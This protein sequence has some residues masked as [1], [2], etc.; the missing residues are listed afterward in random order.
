MGGEG[1]ADLI[2]TGCLASSH[3]I[4]RFRQAALVHQFHAGLGQDALQKG[5]RLTGEESLTEGDHDRT[6]SRRRGF[7]RRRDGWP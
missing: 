4:G 1:G 6:L 7:D 3:E 2:R 5:L